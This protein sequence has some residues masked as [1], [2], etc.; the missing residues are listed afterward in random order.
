MGIVR[1]CGRPPR[2]APIKKPTRDRAPFVLPERIL[3]D[4]RDQLGARRTPRTDGPRLDAVPPR[5]VTPCTYPMPYR[6]DRRLPPR[7]DV[8]ARE[9]APDRLALD[10]PHGISC[11]AEHVICSCRVHGADERPTIEEIR[12]FDGGD[13]RA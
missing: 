1:R 6:L 7:L 3:D 8:V 13:P 2:L 9:P 10:E 4:A 11:D 12:A 5:T